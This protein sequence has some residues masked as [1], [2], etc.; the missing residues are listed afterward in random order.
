MTF[1]ASNRPEGWFSGT[2][3]FEGGKLQVTIRDS[4]EGPPRVV[5][6]KTFELSGLGTDRFTMTN[7]GTGRGGIVTRKR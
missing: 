4:S 7:T 2:W 3:Y 1:R 5:Q 6:Q